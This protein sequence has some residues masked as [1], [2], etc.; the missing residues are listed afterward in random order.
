MVFVLCLVMSE[1]P[2]LPK[3][4]KKLLKQQE[5]IPAKR[6]ADRFGGGPPAKKQKLQ[7]NESTVERGIMS[8]RGRGGSRNG[9]KCRMDAKNDVNVDD[10]QKREDTKRRGYGRS[11]A[12]SR[13]LSRK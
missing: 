12:R 1:I 5:V 13:K 10:A 8:G 6:K 3:N 2:E 11:R 4:Y 7:Q 9:I